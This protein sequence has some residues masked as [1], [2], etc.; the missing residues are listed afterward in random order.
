[1]VY[2]DPCIFKINHKG[3]LLQ[4][5]KHN[6][7]TYKQHYKHTLRSA[8]PLEKNVSQAFCLQYFPNSNHSGYLRLST[9]FRELRYCA[10]THDGSKVFAVLVSH[11]VVNPNFSTKDY[12]IRLYLRQ[13]NFYSCD[14]RLKEKLFFTT[15]AASNGWGIVT[16]R[17]YHTR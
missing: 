17:V 11:V 2:S 1:M 16:R 14:L 6:I 10:Y 15:H 7:V 12:S 3:A 4:I 9:G 8:F 13:R 5:L